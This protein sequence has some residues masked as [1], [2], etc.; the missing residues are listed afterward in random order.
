[1]LAA[2]VALRVGGAAAGRL[3]PE[4]IAAAVRVRAQGGR[5]VPQL[6]PS[7]LAGPLR[8]RL[9]RFRSTG[10][11]ARFVVKGRRV[12]IVPSTS[13]RDVQ[14]GPAAAAVLAALRSPERTA[15][16]SLVPV[17]ARF[18]TADARKLG[19]RQ[20]V[21]SFTTD[22]GVSTANR[23]HNVQLMA[24]YID[25]TLILP[26]EIFSFNRVVGPRSVERGFKVGQAIYGTVAVA[27][28]GGG[29]CQTA[30]TM[31]NN[32][33][34]LGLPI[35]SRFNHTTYIDHYPLGRDATVSWGGPDLVFRNDLATALLVKARYTDET[36]TFTLYGTPS[37]RRVVA[38]TSQ[39]TNIV[40][41]QLR[42]ALDLNAPERSVRTS[43]GTGEEG[44][45][46][47]VTREV[48][49]GDR[50]LG[51]DRFRSRYLDQGPTRIYGPGQ[52][53]PRPYIVI[54]P[55][56]TSSAR[57][58]G[59]RHLRPAAQRRGMSVASMPSTSRMARPR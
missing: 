45:D 17:P 15:R 37:G 3:L 52:E 26:G 50:L 7:A 1:M 31:F 55:R 54:P 6:V 44:F 36:L 59:R 49:D 8:S 35:L 48:W 19:V 22:M 12:A 11:D 39:R 18:S 23:I 53:V 40:P 42:Y 32:A 21:S 51:T 41:P 10:K 33:F 47:T 2:P 38:R 29:V 30:T 57:Q 4:E 9:E 24:D 20:Q 27:S 46:V 56:R 58:A 5:L 14:P 28:I 16:L 25:G 34:E 43:P 13:G